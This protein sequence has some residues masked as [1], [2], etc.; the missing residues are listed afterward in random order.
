[1]KELTRKFLLMSDYA[2]WLV[3]FPVKRE[4]VLFIFT[5]TLLFISR[6]RENPIKAFKGCGRPTCNPATKTINIKVEN[7][8][9]AYVCGNLFRIL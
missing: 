4:G 1:M 6:T 7:C 3:L 8:F 5:W 2:M 9:S